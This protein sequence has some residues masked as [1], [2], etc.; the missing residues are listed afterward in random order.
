MLNVFSDR[1][2]KNYTFAYGVAF[3]FL[4]LK[5][6]KGHDLDNLSNKVWFLRFNFLLKKFCTFFTEREHGAFQIYCLM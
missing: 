4:C 1:I 3:S 6:V 2:D 5:Y